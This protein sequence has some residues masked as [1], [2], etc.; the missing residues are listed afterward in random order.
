MNIK[1]G[2]TLIEL[3]IVVAIIGILS[4]I[5]IPAYNGYISSSKI[6]AMKANFETGQRFIR[7]ETAK[8]SSGSNATT[9]AIN[10]LNAGGKKSPVD[11]SLDAYTQSAIAVANQIAISVNNI[12]ATSANTVITIYAPTGNDPEGNLW[13]THMP[14]SVGITVE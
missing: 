9:V 11:G 14:A 3:M 4:A 13:T 8:K 12:Q 6:A 1:N 7:D 5:A 10:I 2:F